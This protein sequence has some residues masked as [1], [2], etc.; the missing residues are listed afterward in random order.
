MKGPQ[1]FSV[2]NLEDALKAFGRDIWA[3]LCVRI[4][5]LGGLTLWQVL[6][7]VELLLL[8]YAGLSVVLK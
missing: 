2:Q 3:S 5:W 8:S 4:D 1:T 7:L 6:L